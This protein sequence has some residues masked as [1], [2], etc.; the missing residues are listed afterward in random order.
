MSKAKPRSRKA[1]SPSRLTVAECLVRLDERL[2]A[3]HEQ[4]VTHTEQDGENF[5][6]LDRKLDSVRDEVA[7]LKTA[8]AVAEAAGRGAGKQAG[9]NYGAA[10]GGFVGG[11]IAA[12]AT[13]FGWAVK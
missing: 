12:L 9:R 10:A 1:V 6:A 3:F 2:G 7:K 11:L 4:L 13:A 8:H 5:G